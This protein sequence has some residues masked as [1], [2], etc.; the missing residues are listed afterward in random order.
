MLIGSVPFRATTIE[1]LHKLI[2]VAKFDYQGEVISSQAKNLIENLI[3]VD[4]S[5]RF[6]AR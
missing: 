5:K 1:K 6:S 4:V 3:C 2:K